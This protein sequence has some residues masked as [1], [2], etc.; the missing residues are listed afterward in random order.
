MKFPNIAATFK[1]GVRVYERAKIAL[2]S[3]WVNARPMIRMHGDKLLFAIALAVL[4]AFIIRSEKKI[5]LP[6]KENPGMVFTQWWQDDIGNERFQDIVKDFESSHEGIR[7]AINRKSYTEIKEEL[8]NPGT[9]AAG[10]ISGNHEPFDIIALDP[11][12]VPELLAAGTIETTVKAKNNAMP[13]NANAQILSYVN[14][15]FYNINLLREAN[16]SRPPKTRSEFL[17]YAR[18]ISSE[19]KSRYGLAMGLAGSRGVYDDIFPWIWSAG[20]QMVKNGDPAV[21][22]RQV[23][24][25]LG[26]LASL[27]DDGIVNANAFYMDSEKKM[28]DFISGRA[29]FMVAPVCAV[30]LVRK[31]MGDDA[32]GISSVPS[33][34]NTAG[35]YY[36]ASAGLTLG[37]NPLS[38]RKEDAQIFAD[39]LA[40]KTS[41]LPAID[42]PFYSKAWD[43]AISGEPAQD[44]SG[45]PWNTLDAI[46]QH[47]LSALFSKDC[48]PAEAASA[49]QKEWEEALKKPH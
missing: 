27:A 8:F 28:D 6:G 42:D 13:D 30:D 36:Y 9:S 14:V 41:I 5:A 31:Q 11:L 2:Y 22:S 19:D 38:S 15:L 47:E 10:D 39:F 48:T 49:I 1:N 46:F 34:D 37:I 45:L 32:F 29:A 40:E 3:Q 21:N 16:F 7:I 18:A 20:T 23:I 25:A 44:F 26:F 4:A 43:I 17:A 35:V 12:W 24:E 33:S